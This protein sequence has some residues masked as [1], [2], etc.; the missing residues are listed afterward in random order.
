MIFKKDKSYPYLDCTF[1][2]THL[3]INTAAFNILKLKTYKQHV[4]YTAKFDLQ[5]V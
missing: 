3:A 2:F 4:L 5:Y 1:I